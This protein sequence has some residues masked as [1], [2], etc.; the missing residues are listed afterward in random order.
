MPETVP[1][2][3]S[4]DD[5]FHEAIVEFGIHASRRKEYTVLL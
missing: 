2:M 4:D 3:Y 5:I 1:H